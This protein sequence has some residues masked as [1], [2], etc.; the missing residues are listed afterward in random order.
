MDDRRIIHDGQM[1]IGP[2]DEEVG[3]FARTNSRRIKA[4]QAGVDPDRKGGT[5]QR[6]QPGS[7]PAGC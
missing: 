4:A 1:E 3:R 7:S 5:L 2:I 6:W